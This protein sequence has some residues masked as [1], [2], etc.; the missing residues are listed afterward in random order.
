MEKRH[1]ISLDPVSK[2]RTLLQDAPVGSRLVCAILSR[3]SPDIDG[4]ELSQTQVWKEALEFARAQRLMPLVHVLL[5]KQETQIPPDAALALRDSYYQHMLFNTRHYRAMLDVI[6]SLQSFGLEL[7]VL[8]GAFISTVIHR[9]PAVRRSADLD[10][11]VRSVDLEAAAQGLTRLGYEPVSPID[12]DGKFPDLHLRPHHLP[13][14][15]KQ[16]SPLVEVHFNLAPSSGPFTIDIDHLWQRAQQVELDQVSTLAL[17]PI[18]LLLH[19][20]IHTSYHHAFSFGMAQ[21]YDIDAII[22]H[23]GSSLDWSAFVARAKGWRAANSAYI[24][25]LLAR[26]LLDADVPNNVL[27]DL[28]P[29]NLKD[30]LRDWAVRQV[31]AARTPMGEVEDD[32]ADSNLVASP[33]VGFKRTIRSAFPSRQTMAYMYP[34]DERPYLLPLYYLIRSFQLLAR[35]GRRSLTIIFGGYRREE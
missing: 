16:G 33:W 5:S 21:L 31:L 13:G 34:L 24:A 22:R 3:S 35:Y 14:F 1:S 4:F 32:V 11:L 23:Y 6:Q 19:V 12:F 25:L 18:D 17:D 29:E 8:K 20:C 30:D 15:H 2:V 28:S 9:N 7:I 10:I 27:V 26:G